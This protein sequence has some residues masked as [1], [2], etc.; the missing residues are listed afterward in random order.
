VT[1]SKVKNLPASVKAR[2][3]NLAREQKEDFQELLSRYG[4]ERLLDRLSVSQYQDRF[5]LKGARRLFSVE[6]TNTAPDKGHNL[7]IKY[8]VGV[9]SL[10][11]HNEL[12]RLNEEPCNS[13]H[14]S[15][16]IRS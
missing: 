16:S 10:G 2:L 13:S 4:R 8:I 6:S 3:A 15:M 5:I 7:G 9:T 12:E 1:E 11:P 14:R